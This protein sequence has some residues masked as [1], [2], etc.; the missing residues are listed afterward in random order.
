MHIIYA[1]VSPI[2]RRFCDNSLE[3]SFVERKKHG[4][5]CSRYRKC[6]VKDRG[7]VGAPI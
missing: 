7:D 1:R 6:I 4:R 5:E 3:A 2:F